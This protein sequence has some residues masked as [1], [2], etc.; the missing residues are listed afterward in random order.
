MSA[1]TAVAVMMVVIAATV[2]TAFTM[3]M[4]TTVTTT[5][6]H[7]DGLAD[8][9]LSR[10]AVLDDG[11]RKVELLASQ[12]VVGVEGH[13]VIA[14]ILHTCQ[15]TVVVAVHQ[16]DDGSRED[17]VVVEMA[18]HREYLTVD[19]MNA[20]WLISAKGLCGLEGKVEDVALRMLGYFLFKSVE[21]DSKTCDKLEGTLCAS[22]FLEFLLTVSDGIQLVYHRHKLVGFLIHTL[23]Y[24]YLFQVAK[25]IILIHIYAFFGRKYIFFHI[26][27]IL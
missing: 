15:E 22:L 9:L 25:V 16:R 19:L 27:A 1:A 2:L 13:F 20:L 14:D 4:A 23:L 18:I 12:R 8:L 5:C 21:S 11:A 10:I 17:V 26:R 3:M 7:L 24:I 6:Q